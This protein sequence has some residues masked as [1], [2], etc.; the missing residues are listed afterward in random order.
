MNTIPQSQKFK[1]Y[2]IHLTDAEVDLINEKGHDAVHKQSLK[3]DMN[4]SK[5]DTG[6]VAKEAFDLGYYTH[7]SNITSDNF[8]GV[9]AIG[10]MG[11]EECIERLDKMYSC[12]VGDIVEDEAGN[13]KVVANYGF[14]DVA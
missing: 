10:N 13:K 2:Q 11:P 1:L 8:E 5:N 6:S 7:V 9:F 3:L 12:S 4:F 14:K